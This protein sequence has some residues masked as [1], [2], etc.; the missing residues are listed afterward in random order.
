MSEKMIFCLG[1]GKYIKKGMGYQKSYMAF[2]KN[3][4]HGR[5]DEILTLIRDD[6][7]SE[8]KLDFKNGEWV[9]EWK[10]VSKDKW[11]R[12]LEIPESDKEVIEGIIGFELDL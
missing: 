6:I 12:I 2:N 3:V 1:E 8:L 11:E 10:K 5:Y 7:L 4:S 9:N